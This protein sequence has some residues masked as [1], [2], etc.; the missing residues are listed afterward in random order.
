MLTES[1][2]CG[3][4][5]EKHYMQK[6]KGPK[7]RMNSVG[8]KENNQPINQSISVCLAQEK[9]GRIEIFEIGERKRQNSIV[10]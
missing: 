8:L 10:F 6:C 9:C 4:L 5:R 2:Q 1:H 7:V 3:V